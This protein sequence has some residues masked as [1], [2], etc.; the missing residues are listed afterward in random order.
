MD[1]A[2]IKSYYSQRSVD[3]VMGVDARFDERAQE[4]YKGLD[5]KTVFFPPKNYEHYPEAPE[6]ELHSITDSLNAYGE[7]SW[8]AFSVRHVGGTAIWLSLVGGDDYVIINN[9][10][11]ANKELQSDDNM[12]VPLRRS[13]K[14]DIAVVG[15]PTESESSL[16]IAMGVAD[17][18]A[19]S[20]ID[21]RTRAFGFAHA[22][23]TGTALRTSEKAAV[24]LKGEFASRRSDLVAYL[25]EG[26]CTACYP[27]DEKAIDSFIADFGGK[28]E[29]SKVLAQYPQA[30][31][32]FEFDGKKSYTLDH[33][34]FNRYVLAQQVHEIVEAPNCTARSNEHCGSL[35]DGHVPAEKQQ[36]FFSHRRV[37]GK[38]VGWRM[39]DGTMLE[40][41]TSHLTMPRNLAAMV[42]K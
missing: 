10:K 19:V 39:E 1:R 12:Y 18:L 14:T 30:I 15:P 16:V 40:L 33:Y 4:I 17:C 26:V 41:N 34:A 22:G 7:I 31:Q 37:N 25:G 23:R 42:R 27:L 38:T 6:E 11:A 36:P 35:P 9:G 28:T 24:L 5:P 29:V 32:M 20:V 8:R 13:P 2:G 21:E 3:E